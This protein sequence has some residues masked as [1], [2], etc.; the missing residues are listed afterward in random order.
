MSTGRAR[1]ALSLALATLL[2]PSLA[3]LLC[4]VYARSC[5]GLSLA[6]MLHASPRSVE[7]ETL[8]RRLYHNFQLCLPPLTAAAAAVFFHA[9]ARCV[10]G[11]RAALPPA[12]SLS[13]YLSLARLFCVLVAFAAFT[14]LDVFTVFTAIDAI[15]AFDAFDRLRPSPTSGFTLPPS[16]GEIHVSYVNPYLYSYVYLYGR[17]RRPWTL[18]TVFL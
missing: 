17:R 2:F 12:L 1:R 14:A 18:R 8:D 5:S 9:L 15:D 13:L 11:G 6:L 10:F 16:W 7:N 4:R 3:S